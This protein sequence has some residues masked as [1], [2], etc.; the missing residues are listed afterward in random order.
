L[1]YVF[2][3][4]HTN[5]NNEDIGKIC[6]SQWFESPFIVGNVKYSTAEHWMMAQKALLISDCFIF[7]VRIFDPVLGRDKLCGCDVY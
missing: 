7:D 4:G 6:F 3:W 1:K 5:K 2:F